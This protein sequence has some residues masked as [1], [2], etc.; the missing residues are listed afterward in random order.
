MKKQNPQ[1]TIFENLTT[2]FTVTE[3]RR[4]A[5]RKTG[6]FFSSDNFRSAGAMLFSVTIHI[7]FVVAYFALADL[8]ETETPPIREITFIDMTEELPAETPE[9]QP[10]PVKKIVQTA[11]VLPETNELPQPE[12]GTSVA[13]AGSD[14]IFLDRKRKQA[15]INIEKV[16]PVANAIAKPVDLIKISP[17][18]GIR[19]DEKIARPAPI[20]LGDNQ[21]LLAS[22]APVTAGI[23][24]DGPK[25]PQIQ[26]G[27]GT[28][29][30]NATN[31]GSIKI[32]SKPK[33][34]DL[35][36]DA[37]K[38]DQP[39]TVITGALA[40]R[41]IINKIIPPFP[42]WA[43][44]QGVSAT[45][46]LRF[47]VMENGVVREN[48]VVVRTSGSGEWDRLVIEALKQWQFAALE[49]SGIRLDQSGVI[50][51]QFVI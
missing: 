19:D 41:K 23:A 30:S 18:K 47:T 3:F 29:K 48:V 17:A 12:T 6:V 13:A 28:G 39:G 43:K 22:T 32:D 5:V 34:K 45:V 40:N 37:L 42:E 2:R 35:N 44:R 11:A 24:F 31:S 21:N 46:A 51:F 25:T 7:L 9:I 16:Q 36:P 20:S 1:I 50:T 8:S 27:A 26:L 15:P 49:N 10:A 38:P 14:K 4:S 33:Q